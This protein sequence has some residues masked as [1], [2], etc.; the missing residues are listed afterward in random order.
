MQNEENMNDLTQILVVDKK[1]KKVPRKYESENHFNKLTSKNW[2]IFSYY[3][4]IL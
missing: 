1:A 3:K 2:S 4:F